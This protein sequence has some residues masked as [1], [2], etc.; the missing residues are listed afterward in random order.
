[1]LELFFKILRDVDF[2]PVA[3][4][5]DGLALVWKHQVQVKVVFAR[6]LPADVPQRTKVAVIHSLSVENDMDGVETYTVVL[7]QAVDFRDDEPA[8]LLRHIQSPLEK[9]GLVGAE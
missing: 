7:C 1:M 6:M 3:E 4:I 2:R 8:A 5:N 9:K